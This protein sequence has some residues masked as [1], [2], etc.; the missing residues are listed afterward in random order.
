MLF[1]LSSRET[2]HTH[3]GYALPSITKSLSL[4]LPMEIER[5]LLLPGE[6]EIEYESKDRYEKKEGE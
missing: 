1:G 4:I 2:S 5:S 6:I 3:H